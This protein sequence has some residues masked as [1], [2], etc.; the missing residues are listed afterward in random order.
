VTERAPAGRVSALPNQKPGL[1]ERLGLSREDVAGAVW[2]I[3]PS[4]R[5]HRGAAAIARVSRE[6]GGG[7]R[8]LGALARLPGAGL[9]YRLVARSRGRLSALWGDPPP[10]P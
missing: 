3:E 8:L 2:A 9:G 6:M 7:W 4:G 10:Y 1:T 5:R